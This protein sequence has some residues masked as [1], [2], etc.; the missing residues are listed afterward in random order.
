MCYYVGCEESGTWQP[1]LVLHKSEGDPGTR[2]RFNDPSKVSACSAH[3][4]AV[5]PSDLLSPEGFDV[6]VRHLRER[7]QPVPVRKLTT[8]EWEKIK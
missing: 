6:L 5:K 4:P 8:L 3:Q 7:A 1:V 2:V